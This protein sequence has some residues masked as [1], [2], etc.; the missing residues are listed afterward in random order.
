M[1]S[2]DLYVVLVVGEF[3][4]TIFTHR[5]QLLLK[6]LGARVNFQETL[7]RMVNIALMDVWA[8]I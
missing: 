5:I 2:M 3:L 1:I 7:L 6:L 8:E 4:M